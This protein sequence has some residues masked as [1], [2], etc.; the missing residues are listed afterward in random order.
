MHDVDKACMRHAP[1]AM[2]PWWHAFAA[3]SRG[4]TERTKGGREFPPP[5]AVHA[6]LLLEVRLLRLKPALREAPLPDLPMHLLLRARRPLEA[7]E[8]R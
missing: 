8:A 1:C 7:L 6:H 5:H 4:R 2:R 3:P